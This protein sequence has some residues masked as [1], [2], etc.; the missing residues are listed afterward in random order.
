LDLDF[1]RL[2]FDSRVEEHLS[3]PSNQPI[4]VYGRVPGHQFLDELEARLG[5]ARAVFADGY[6]AGADL[7][8]QPLAGDLQRLHDG[9]QP[10]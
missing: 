4:Q 2:G 9:T 5:I 7:P 3:L 8:C 1:G 6:V 10:C